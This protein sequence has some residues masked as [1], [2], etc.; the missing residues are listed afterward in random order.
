VLSAAD[1]DTLSGATADAAAA[2]ATAFATSL[3]GR[4]LIGLGMQADLPAAAAI[5]SL[6]VVPRL[7]RDRDRDRDQDR[8]NGR[9]GTAAG[10]LR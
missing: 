5:D 3:G 6:P 8:A 7:D 4:N 9:D 10:W 1:T 2:I